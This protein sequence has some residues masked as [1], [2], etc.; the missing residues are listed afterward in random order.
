MKKTISIL[1][2]FTVLLFAGLTSAH[3]GSL[4]EVEGFVDPTIGTEIYIDSAS[5]NNGYTSTFSEVTYIFDFTYAAENVSMEY[6]SLEFEDEVFKSIGPI[7]FSQP[8]DWSYFTGTSGSGSV[9][10][11]G[12]AGTGVGMGSTL[13]FIV[14]D[15]EVYN[16]ALTDAGLWQEGHVWGQSWSAKGTLEGRDGGSTDLITTRDIAV[17]PEPVSSILFVVGAALLGFRR[18]RK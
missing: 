14:S 9:Y 8:L 13:K 5:A 10:E 4:M 18:F 3:A 16:S 6:I 2:I 15:V 1:L 17:V 12:S 7:T 11:M